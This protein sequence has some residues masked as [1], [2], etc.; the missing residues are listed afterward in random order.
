MSGASLI[1]GVRRADRGDRRPPGPDRLRSARAAS[2]AGCGC[3]RRCWR[4][5]PT[6]P[7][8]TSRR[9]PSRSRCSAS[10]LLGFALALPPLRRLSGPWPEDRATGRDPARG[11]RRGHDLQLQL[12]GP[13]LAARAPL[14]V[15]MLV[16]A[17]RERD[18]R[19][20]SLPGFACGSGSAEPDPR[21]ALGIGDPGRRRAAGDLPARQLLELQGLQPVR[22]PAPRSGSATCASRSTRSRPSGSGPP[23][24]FRITPANSTTPE[25]AFYLGGAPGPGGVRLGPRPGAVA[26][27]VGPALGAAR[28]DARS[29][30]L[31]SPLG[32]PYTQAKALA[33]AAPLIMVIALRGLL[34]ADSL[35]GEE[36]DVPEG[37][38]ASL[39]AAAP[40]PP[41]RTGF[42]RAPADPRLRRRGRLL[43]PAPAAAGG[44]RARLPPPGDA[45]HAADR[46]R[47]ERALPR[48]R[49]LRLLGA[50]RLGGLRADH[51]PLR[52]RGDRTRSTGPPT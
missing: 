25:I 15:W 19:A 48:P 32:T 2:A 31:R 39:V 7:P 22:A 46:R 36:A 45:P 14:I 11:D 40:A 1:E 52:R 29:T 4:R 10:P 18:G 47:P 9:A 30:W 28:G 24:E 12:P 34:S 37:R 3:R 41:A 17:I 8:P 50:D 26:A 27:G 6:W 23:G 5:A 16:I 42:A 33:I 49:Q 44:G 35:P 38:G 43:D 21:I 51:Q 13:R 20:P